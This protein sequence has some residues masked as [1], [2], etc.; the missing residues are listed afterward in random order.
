MSNHEI[1]KIVKSPEGISLVISK[2]EEWST[3][4]GCYYNTG[5]SCPTHTE[6]CS[7]KPNVI[8]KVLPTNE[9]KLKTL[10][11]E[12]YNTPYLK[13]EALIY[14]LVQEKRIKLEEFSILC[15]INR[16]L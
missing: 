9:E 2:E 8:F 11:D 15:S 12:V 5:G 16:G 10:K 1:G 3:C 4:R 6:G 7:D 14:K 13:A